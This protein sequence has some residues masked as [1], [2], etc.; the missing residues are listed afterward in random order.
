MEKLQ[1]ALEK[2][3]E[4]RSIQNAIAEHGRV[5]PSTASVLGTSSSQTFE[6]SDTAAAWSKLGQVNSVPEAMERNRIVTASAGP[7][8]MSLDVLRTK[9]QLL[10]EKNNWSRLGITSATADC[11]KSTLA[12]NLAFGFARQ[13]ELRAIL[14]EL[15]LRRP[16]MSQILATT[17]D[18]DVT[19]MLSGDVP[20]AE[21]ALRIDST[22]AISMAKKPSE[23]PA[24]VLLR[25]QTHATLGNIEQ[26]YSPNLLIFDLPPLLGGDDTRAFLK[27]IDCALIIAK[28]EA[29]SIAEIDQCEREISESTNVLG[30]V[31][32]QYRFSDDRMYY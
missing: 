11:G 23:D 27:D 31:L 9:I 20:F 22:V 26:V 29:T 19:E 6:E 3:R 4:Q 15:D 1:K 14:I 10:M 32:N 12:C 21:Q 5:A 30:V 7:L 2:A 16:S 18:H 25:R 8:G 24:S 17:P 13:R 28:A